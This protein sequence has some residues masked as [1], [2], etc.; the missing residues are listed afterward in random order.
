MLLFVVVFITTI[1]SSLRHTVTLRCTRIVSVS[2]YADNTYLI[3]P[4]NEYSLHTEDDL[5]SEDGL[6]K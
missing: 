6:V 2:I 4:L 1:E 3:H 5:G